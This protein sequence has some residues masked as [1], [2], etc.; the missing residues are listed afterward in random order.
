[1]KKIV[2]IGFLMI[3]AILAFPQTVM[4][5][6]GTAVL[7][8][9]V[10]FTLTFSVTGSGILPDMTPGQ[11]IQNTTATNINATVVS[12]GPWKMTT[13][14]AHTGANIA[15]SAGQLAEW[16]G[17]SAYVNGGAYL[18]NPLQVSGNS[19]INW[20][21]VPAST[22]AQQ[23]ASGAATTKTEVWPWFRIDVPGDAQYLTTAGHTYRI[24]VTLE[25]TQN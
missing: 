15:G 17:T 2:L 12:N 18:S 20:Y 8:G 14:D 4:A 1:M 9:T 16:D 10:P 5:D 11:L 7:T 22:S 24:V 3:V 21:N 6:T 13:Y 19:G 25:T 23:I